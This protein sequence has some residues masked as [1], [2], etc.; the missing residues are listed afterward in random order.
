MAQSPTPICDPTPSQEQILLAADI[1]MDVRYSRDAHNQKLAQLRAKLPTTTYD[2]ALQLYSKQTGAA[3]EIL[4]KILAANPSHGPA[5]LLRA[6]IAASTSFKDVPA[7]KA[8]VAQFHKACPNSYAAVSEFTGAQDLQWLAQEAALLRSQLQGRAGRLEALAYPV[9]WHWERSSRRSDQMADVKALWAKDF[10]LLRSDKFPR[11]ESWRSAITAMSFLEDIEIDWLSADFARFHPHSGTALRARLKSTQSSADFEALVRQY[12]ASTSVPAFWIDR[13]RD[14]PEQLPSAYL[15]MKSAMALDPDSFNSSPPYQIG[16][17]EDLVRKNLRMDLVPSFIFAGIEAIQRETAKEN[18]SDLYPNPEKFRQKQYD[19]WYLVAYFP[20]IEAYAALNKP[21]EA[22]DIVSQAQTILNRSRPPADSSLEQRNTHLHMEANFWRVK[23]ILAAARGKTF[24]ALIAYR[25]ALSCYPPRSSRPD[26]RD[27]V[28]ATARAL[29]KQLGA[30]EE[31]WND[32]EARQP[33][34][35]F[36]AGVGTSN[37][38]QTLAIKQPELKIKDMLGREFTP[39]QLAARKTFVNLWAT[40]CGP[41]REELPYL[42]KLAQQLKDKP[43]IAVIALN[44]DEDI[45]PVE[46]FLKRFNFTFPNNLAQTYA[47]A[48][49]PPMAIPAN[50]LIAPGKTEAIY[51]DLSGDAWVAHITK[52]ITANQ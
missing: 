22:V 26:Q 46:S 8:D 45:T 4:N 37:A 9:L 7:L 30:T 15:A 6:R 51:P 38:W 5:L 27:E 2:Q 17:A 42:E 28:M 44:V 35:S 31:A 23:G 3:R 13:V 14:N 25:N 33:L 34:D 40:W 12:P 49:L 1:P 20:L 10:E 47:Y 52:A 32:W 29:A 36:R 24:D 50:Y 11:T 19:T 39:A 21:N 41:C 43:E 16:M 18:N 48:M